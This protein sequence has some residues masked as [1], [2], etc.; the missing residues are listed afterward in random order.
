MTLDN[1]FQNETVF[2]PYVCCGDPSEEFTIR[3][4]QTLVANGAGAI[5]LGIPFSDPI[6]DGKLIQTA[7]NRALTNGMTPKKALDIISKLREM[8]INVPIMV[9]TYYNIVYSNGIE[10]FVNEIKE[11]GADGLIVPDIT[12]DE[13]EELDNL[14]KKNGIA[15]IYFIT[16]NTPENRMK[17]IAEKSAG[18]LYAVS[19]LGTTGMRDTVSS[20]AIE[21]IKQAKKIT[22]TPIVA[23][24]GIS[25][26]KQARIFSN[27]DADG[28]I[29][30]SKLV[31]IYSNHLDDVDKACDEIA[32]F[33]KKITKV[34]REKD[35]T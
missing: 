12:I 31:D 25:D 33:T 9:M 26:E 23:G 14:C 3:I 24:F 28:I 34:L 30:G 20:E 19:V 8:K 35:D 17:K 5:E 21:L 2:M 18:F 15:L 32:E 16:P 10:N 4:I 29:I 27:S 1:L 11:A 22:K 7:S 6:A 13:S